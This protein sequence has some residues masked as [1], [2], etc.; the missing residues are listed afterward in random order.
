MPD[1]KKK[2]VMTV[3]GDCQAKPKSPNLEIK[4]KEG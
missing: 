1:S 4:K 2:V 3:I